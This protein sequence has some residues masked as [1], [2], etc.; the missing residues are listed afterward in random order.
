MQFGSNPFYLIHKIGS[1]GSVMD[2][3]KEINSGNYFIAGTIAFLEILPGELDDGY[4]SFRAF[5]RANGTAGEGMAWHHIVEQNPSNYLRFGPYKLHNT[6]NLIKVPHGKGT[7]H[8]QISGYYSS[9]Q[10]FT[11]GQTVRKWLSTKSYE[12]QFQFG[13]ETLK[14]YGWE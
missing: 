3:A 6:K 1:T 4:R 9:I 12:E 8:A 11:G 13:I 10:P 2:I 14:K 5:K 7:I